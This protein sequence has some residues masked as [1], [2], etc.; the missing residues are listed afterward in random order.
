M[1]YS[2]WDVAHRFATNIGE[3]CTGSNM[4]FEGNVIYSY[5]HHFPIAIKYNGKLLWN[6]DRYSNSTARHQ[7]YVMGACGHYDFVHC[8][9]LYATPGTKYFYEKNFECWKNEIEGIL[10]KLS[11]ARK[12]E[13][14]WA[15]IMR[16]IGKVQKFCGFFGVKMPKE[17]AAYRDSDSAD[18]GAIMER[19]KLEEKR[20]EERAKREE[21]KKIKDFMDF[22]VNSY[23]GKYQIVRLRQDKNRFE[24]SMG[25]QIPFEKGREFYEKLR[26]GLLQVGDQLLYYRVSSVGDV[27][28][29]G[30]HTFKKKYLLD[31]GKKV[32]A[33]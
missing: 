6:D 31:Y 10:P 11:K 5:G 28:R 23:Y 13:K 27:V 33:L 15:E 12:P 16:V 29:V 7:S 19:V 30:C 8:S 1:G 9:Y 32:F 26:D 17:L 3:H 21:R 22:K 14:Y 25:V 20:K 18:M 2:N 4:F 24:T